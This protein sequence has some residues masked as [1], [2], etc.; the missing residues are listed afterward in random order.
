MIILPKIS[1]N[2]FTLIELL[3]VATIIIVL[4][5]IGLVSYR[6]VSRNSRNAKRKADIETVR[7]AA[8]MYRSETGDYPEWTGDT[9]NE[10][11]NSW[12]TT[13]FAA[14]YLTESAFT[15]PVNEG[16]YTYRYRVVSGPPPIEQIWTNLEPDGTDYILT[17]P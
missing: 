9:Q 13:L 6:T 10:R 2:G 8:I 3:V 11:F 12:V 17:L 1:K 7:Q 16:D 5:T 14:G 15:D 4:T